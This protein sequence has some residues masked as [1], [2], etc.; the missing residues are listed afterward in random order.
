MDLLGTP[1]KPSRTLG[2]TAYF[3]APDER[4]DLG[5]FRFYASRKGLTRMV[6]LAVRPKDGDPGTPYTGVINPLSVP[7]DQQQVV[8]TTWLYIGLLCEFLCMNASEDGVRMIPLEQAQ[9][10]LDA[11]YTDSVTTVYNDDDPGSF[12]FSYLNGQAVLGLMANVETSL[13]FTSDDDP[14]IVPATRYY[15]L[16]ACLRLTSS[17]IEAAPEGFSPSLKLAICALGE[18]LS[19]LVMQSKPFVSLE[20]NGVARPWMAFAW[21]K[22][23]LV[24]GSP[25]RQQM[26][27]RGWCNSDLSR[28]DGTY[29]RLQT[30]FYLSLMDRRIPG[31]D[32]AGC[33]EDRCV[34]GQIVDGTY[35]LSHDPARE[36]DCD[37]VELEVDLMAVNRVLADPEMETFPVLLVEFP[38]EQDPGKI[39]LKVEAF[40]EDVEYVAISHVWADGL[41][42]TK[43]NTLQT[44][45][46]ARLGRLIKAVED[47]FNA[48]NPEQP[49]VKYRVWI[50]TLCVP[51]APRPGETVEPERLRIYNLA[52]GRMKDVYIGAAHVLVLDKALNI[53]DIEGLHQAEA[54]LRVF[55]SSQWMRR[56]WCLQEGVFA[57]SLY[58]Q[59]HDRPVHIATHMAQLVEMGKSDFRC[60]LI[61]ADLNHEFA[62]LENT[63]LQR[64]PRHHDFLL[65][66]QSTLSYRAVT[67]AS[68]EP[69][70]I[71]TLFGLDVPAIL[72][73]PRELEPRMQLIWQMIESEVG[74]IPALVVFRADNTLTAPGWGW[75]SRSFLR[76]GNSPEVAGYKMLEYIDDH[77]KDLHTSNRIPRAKIVPGRGLEVALPGM[78]LESTPFVDG[79]SLHAWDC[80]I[81]LAQKEPIAYFYNESEE[82][83]YKMADWYA[84]SGSSADG[85]GGPRETLA[86]S[87]NN[88]NQNGGSPSFCHIVDD[89][90][91]PIALLRSENNTADAGALWLLTHPSPPLPPSSA[92]TQSS[93]SESSPTPIR[94]LRKVIIAPLSPAETL[95]TRTLFSISQSVA[96]SPEGQTLTRTLLA[97]MQRTG[98]VAFQIAK[99][100]LQSLLKKAAEEAWTSIPGFP[101]AVE[102]TLGAEMRQY[103]WAG[104]VMRFPHARIARTVGGT[105]LEDGVKWIVD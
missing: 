96:K 70:C 73:A 87:S 47:D 30:V 22:E 8:Y 38:D 31:R 84:L 33:G 89:A 44:C 14:R 53:Y 24:P 12:K 49:P 65:A 95:L 102:E 54:L 41:G 98:D 56:L 61:T 79:G 11:I 69:L 78:L 7:L 55:A 103:I 82:T 15:H 25:V 32:H 86:P 34:A 57:R 105:R 48:R 37:C 60:R 77:S 104:A 16:A 18:V 26:L 29:S 3:P 46:V 94:W 63:R 36:A 66:I 62:R 90:S 71:A 85:G 42:N 17:M 4:W 50:D 76:S 5:S 6:P 27:E 45:Q 72:A 9:C 10:L 43:A 91:G 35:K 101:E 83:W 92:L 23:F 52:L 81:S 88:L 19:L 64:R 67:V 59:F 97:N 58:F 28:A 21:K 51:V 1:T 80:L 74:S 100:G 2:K 68:D 75:A 20:A 93:S 40:T 39:M 99:T 13:N